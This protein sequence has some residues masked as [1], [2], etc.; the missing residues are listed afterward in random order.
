MDTDERLEELS[1]K[2][3]SGEPIS[4]GEAVA[5]AA[6]QDRL[7]EERNKSWWLRFKHWLKY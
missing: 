6:Y 5:V 2:V 1:N 3:R 4:I 7:R